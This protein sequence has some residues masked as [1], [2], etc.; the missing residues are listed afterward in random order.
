[1]VATE[2]GPAYQRLLASTA[3]SQLGDRLHALALAAWTFGHTGS[4]AK[5]GLV[6]VAATLPA[7]F[8]G[9]LAGAVVDRFDRRLVMV[10]ADLFRAILAL[11]FTVLTFLQ[12]LDLSL[13]ILLTAA[14]SVGTALFQPAALSAPPRLVPASEL[15]RATGGIEGVIQGMGV[16]GPALGGGLLALVGMHAPG[17]AL[18]FALNALSFLASA[19]LLWGLSPMPA[20][21]SAHE[22]PWSEAL[23]GG[24]RLLGR[25][26]SIAGALAVF[27]GVN[28][29]TMPVLLFMPAFSTRFGVGPGGLGM[30]EGALGLG[31]AIA[32]LGWGKR[33]APARRW[34]VAVGGLALVALAIFGM[35]LWPSYA[36]HL[37]ALGLAGLGMGSLNVMMITHFQSVVPAPEMGRFFALLTSACMALIPFSH[38][39]FGMAGDLVDPAQLLVGCGLMV[40]VASVA[41]ALVPGFREH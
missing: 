25:E 40:F 11:L 35:G 26:P 17:L 19:A 6:L 1:M 20:E 2:L 24:L 29:F 13:A 27:A 3:A 37:L 5:M 38:L 30:M 12:L 14:L 4:N 9:P 15:V 33:G 8:L 7:V 10:V 28:L 18:A 39:A 16:L 22:E 21:A 23:G 41:L 34:P 31:M 36:H 32:A